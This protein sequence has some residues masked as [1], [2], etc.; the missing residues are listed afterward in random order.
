MTTCNGIS[1]R[2]V[3]SRQALCGCRASYPQPQSIHTH[4]P[5]SHK[6]VMSSVKAADWSKAIDTEINK[7]QRQKTWEAV[8]T[9]PKRYV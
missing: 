1:S 5:H 7:L 9:L 2:G 3:T 6:T 4:I 8:K